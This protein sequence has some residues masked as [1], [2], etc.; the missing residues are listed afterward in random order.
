MYGELGSLIF[1]S[2]DEILHEFSTG[3]LACHIFFQIK[4]VRSRAEEAGFISRKPGRMQPH[5]KR[6]FGGT[7]PESNSSLRPAFLNLNARA[8]VYVFLISWNFTPFFYGV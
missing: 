7:D 1:L 8:R 5:E 2:S 3:Y 4:K 6:R